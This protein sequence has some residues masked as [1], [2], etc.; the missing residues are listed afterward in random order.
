MNGQHAAVVFTH[1]SADARAAEPLAQIFSQLVEHCNSD[2]LQFV[3]TDALRIT[4]IAAAAERSG[5]A[6]ADLCVRIKAAAQPGPLYHHDAD[7]IV[8]LRKPHSEH[9]RKPQFD[10]SNVWR[11]PLA[12]SRRRRPAADAKCEL[13][14]G[15]LSLAL[16]ADAIV[17][18][19]APAGIVLDPF[20]GGG[21]TLLAA[22]ETGRICHAIGSD[23]PQVDRAVRRWQQLTSTS[24]VHGELGLSFDELREDRYVGSR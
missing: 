6:V 18:S 22:E 17:E 9:S 7:F 4:N 11:E 2:A 16:V 13:S 20:L 10:R 3:V 23:A 5:L 1:L 14:Q 8:V 24:V 21:S 15:E 12:R 19:S